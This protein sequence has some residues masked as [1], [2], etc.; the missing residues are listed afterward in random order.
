VLKTDP[1]NFEIMD[2]ASPGEVVIIR[3]FEVNGKDGHL[4]FIELELE[5]NALQEVHCVNA[6]R[7]IPG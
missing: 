2:P 6:T 5:S 7:F 3:C 1:A 4:P